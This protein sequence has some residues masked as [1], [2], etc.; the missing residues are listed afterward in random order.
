MADG[1]V[2]F[3]G[4]RIEFPVWQALGS[5]ATGETFDQPE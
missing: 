2:R 1:S 5:R 3:V 4:D